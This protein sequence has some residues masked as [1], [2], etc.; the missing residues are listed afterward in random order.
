MLVRDIVPSVDEVVFP[1]PTV[2]CPSIAGLL[3]SFKASIVAALNLVFTALASAGV[4][5]FPI[6]L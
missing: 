6:I 1:L 4:T 5:V 3:V 2:C